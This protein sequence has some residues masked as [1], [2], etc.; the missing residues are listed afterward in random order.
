MEDLLI[1]VIQVALAVLEVLLDL[2]AYLPFDWPT[3]DFRDTG[4]TTSF[5]G[6]L[7]VCLIIG[8]GIGLLISLVHPQT[9]IRPVW[10]RIVN[11]FLSPVVSGCS[12]FYL[13]KRRQRRNADVRP[14]RHF[15][16]AA[17]LSFG[18]LFIRLMNSDQ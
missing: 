7:V 9:F 13:A 16:Y 4:R 6:W 17:S 14:W 15:W 12:A 11:L 5:W 18:L 8:A 2:F 10:L 1:I 3:G